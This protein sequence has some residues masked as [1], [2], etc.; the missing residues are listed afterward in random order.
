MLNL[1]QLRDRL[2]PAFQPF[3]IRF[4][5]GRSFEVP[6]PD[7]IAVG[8]GYVVLVDQKTNRSHTIDALHIVSLD[9]PTA[10]QRA[11]DGS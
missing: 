9:T 4:T 1:Q 11:G 6:H 3:L 10:E 5:D 8:R 2:G 7:F